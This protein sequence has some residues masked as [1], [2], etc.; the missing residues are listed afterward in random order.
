MA[1]VMDSHGIIMVAGY[2]IRNLE[3]WSNQYLI[4]TLGDRPLSVAV[5]PN[6]LDFD[7]YCCTK[8]CH[9][10][11]PIIVRY[12]DAV[13]RDSDEKWH[14]AEPHYQKMTM[15]SLLSKLETPSKGSKRMAN[16]AR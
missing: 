10:H 7:I 13:T 9:P 12:A 4:D 6:G 8:V 15:R 16:T 14:F 11:H 2:A 5:T 1:I 3:R